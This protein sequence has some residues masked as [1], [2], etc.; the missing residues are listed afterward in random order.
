MNIF[1]CSV[2]KEILHKILF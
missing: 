1:V 2:T